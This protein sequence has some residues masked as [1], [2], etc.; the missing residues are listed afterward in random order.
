MFPVI[1][2]GI[3]LVL[4]E[5]VYPARLLG[6]RC[7]S[8]DHDTRHAPSLLSSS[9][10]NPTITPSVS[11]IRGMSVKA[12]LTQY[13][14][15]RLSSARTQVWHMIRDSVY[16]MT[17]LEKIQYQL[18]EEI[19]F[20]KR[21]IAQECPDNPI[22]SGFK[23]YSQVDED[24]II[25]ELFRRVSSEKLDRTLIEIGCGDGRENN[26]HYLMLQ[27]YRGFWVDG[28]D[29]NIAYLNTGLGLKDGTSSRLKIVQ[30]F[31]DSENICDTIAE[32]CRF[33][34]SCEPDIL[35]LDIDGN[36]LWILKKALTVCR[37]K[38]LC[39]EYN[40]KFPPPLALTIEYNAKHQWMGDDYQGASLQMFCNHLS[41]YT[42]VTCNISGSNAF[43]VRYDLRRHFTLHPIEK[44][45]QPSRSNLRFLSA[46]HPPSLKWLKDSL[47]N[48]P[49]G[50]GGAADRLNGSVVPQAA[51]LDTS[52]TVSLDTSSIISKEPTD[53]VGSIGPTSSAFR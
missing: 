48:K 6:G 26:T 47:S 53:S 49:A 38:F 43:L 1:Y 15:Q 24:G 8:G 29:R 51:E 30:R 28:F 44:L 41:D 14:R 11:G 34:G 25:Q 18:R 50:C 23:V 22:L 16:G 7:S 3:V 37:P 32:A 27:G 46:G 9:P 31:I 21:M 45:Y 10:E 35:S 39:V 36:D 20:L 19:Y 40:A 5:A 2:T 4:S 42:L 52:R 17:P 33:I 13:A 12:T